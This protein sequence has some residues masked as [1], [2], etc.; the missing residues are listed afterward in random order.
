MTAKSRFKWSLQGLRVF[1][2][3]GLIR[4]H[5]TYAAPHETGLTITDE[6][7]AD[8]D[9]PGAEELLVAFQQLSKLAHPPGQHSAVAAPTKRKKP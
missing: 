4:I 9:G 5:A 6:T 7:Y 1:K 2:H 8:V 3:R